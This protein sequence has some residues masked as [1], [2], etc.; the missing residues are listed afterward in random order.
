MNPLL[1]LQATAGNRAVAE[2]MVQRTPGDETPVVTVPTAAEAADQ[3]L[4]AEAWLLF[5]SLLGNAPV[6]TKALN[7]DYR[8]QMAIIQSAVG[9]PGPIPAAEVATTTTAMGKA[10][11]TVARS[12]VA[13]MRADHKTLLAKTQTDAYG[14]IDL[15]LDQGDANRANGEQPTDQRDQGIVYLA[16]KASAEEELA[17]ARDWG[18]DI[19]KALRDLPADAQH[20]FEA[21]RDGWANHAAQEDKPIT[22]QAQVDLSTFIDY[23]AETINPMRQRRFA[24]IARARRREAEALTEANDQQLAELRIM[25]ADKRR[26]AFMAGDASALDDVSNAL[27]AVAGAIED[28]RSAAGIITSRVDQLNA[29]VSA[30]S[31][32]GKGLISLPDMPAGMSGLADTLVSANEKVK[33]VIELLEL[34]GPAKTKLEEGVKYL[35]GVDLALEHFAGKSAN[36]FV[37]VYVGSYLGPGIK[38]CIASI[39]T[40]AN[41]ISEDNRRNIG[42]GQAALVQN[43]DTEPGGEPMYLFIA[44]VFRMGGAAPLSDPVWE[45]LSDHRGDL[46]HAVGVPL[47]KSRAL[48]PSW[49]SANRKAL[50]ESLYGSTRQPH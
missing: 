50:W 27:G 13:R 21:A 10:V 22:P 36:P 49:A 18:Y 25:L 14:V 43:W 5:V 39:G 29:A 33:Q 38:N 16:I 19:P 9:G 46:E 28:T 11:G 24:D 3:L 26:S 31:K 30:V 40:I 42:A 15:A 34:V 20:M 32:S 7:A 48:V 4:T 45:Y 6:P 41:I 44:S 12:L 35:K 17:E 1:A 8:S 23:T 37:A 47:P 2:L